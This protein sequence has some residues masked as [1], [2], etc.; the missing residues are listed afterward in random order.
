MIRRP[1]GPHGVVVGVRLDPIYAEFLRKRAQSE[2]R[3][4]SQIARA[5]IQRDLATRTT[6]TSSTGAVAR[7]TVTA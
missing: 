5:A 6:V 3:T 4:M 7:F 2:G 1:G